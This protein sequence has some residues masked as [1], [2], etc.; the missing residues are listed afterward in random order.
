MANVWPLCTI[1]DEFTLFVQN[2]FSF[3][4]HDKVIK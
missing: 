4:P 1:I 2:N 3:L